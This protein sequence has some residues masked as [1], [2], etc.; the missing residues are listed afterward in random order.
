M[1]APTG[2]LVVV[3]YSLGKCYDMTR[4]LVP[5]TFYPVNNEKY[6]TN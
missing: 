6:D 5:E 3:Y 4:C 1:H 2:H